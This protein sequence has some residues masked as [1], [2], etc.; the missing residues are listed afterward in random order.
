MNV[1][2]VDQFLDGLAEAGIG[3]WILA[4]L[5]VTALFAFGFV[6]AVKFTPKKEHLE[7]PDPHSRRKKPIQP[8]VPS[9]STSS[10]QARGNGT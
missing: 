7:D 2:N 5:G 9:D 1:F 3:T 10:Q 6:L 8:P 4:F